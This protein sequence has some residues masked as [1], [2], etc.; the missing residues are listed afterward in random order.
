MEDG[1]GC[2]MSKGVRDERDH[3]A[4]KELKKNAMLLES[5]E[6]TGKKGQG[7]ARSG[8]GESGRRPDWDAFISNAQGFSLDSKGSWEPWKGCK[9]RCSVVR[10]VF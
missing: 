2:S 3:G 10:F 8:P 7:V 5:G 6:N 1:C 4:L 9:C